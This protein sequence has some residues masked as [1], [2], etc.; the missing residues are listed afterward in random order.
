MKPR[1]ALVVMGAW[2]MGS[3]CMSI[4]ATENF[5]TID[6]LLETSTNAEFYAAVQKLGHGPARDLLR[7][8]SSELNRL[9]F[10]DVE[11]RATRARRLRCGWTRRL[12][13]QHAPRAARW[14]VPRCSASS[15]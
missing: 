14:G 7:Y 6:R 10:P 5:Y 2:T 13:E 11:R 12:P 4:V 3:I 15:C 9:Y 1:W 8:L